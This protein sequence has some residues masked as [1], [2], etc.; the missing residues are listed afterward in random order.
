VSNSDELA[1]TKV[2]MQA[3]EERSPNVHS[4]SVHADAD[5]WFSCRHIGL[6]I[7][8]PRLILTSC[9]PPPSS[10]PLETDMRMH[11]RQIGWELLQAVCLVRRPRMQLLLMVLVRSLFD[12]VLLH[13]LY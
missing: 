4:A 3:I 2:D 12:E 5:L 8:C 9:P 7:Y 13:T 10:T 6:A 11:K 1:V